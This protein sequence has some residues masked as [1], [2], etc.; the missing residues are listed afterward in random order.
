MSI[1][2]SDR[3]HNR[4]SCSACGL[5]GICLPIAVE[6]DQIAALESVVQQGR[7]L[8]RGDH[9]FRMDDP[10][11]CIYAVRSGCVKS[12]RLSERGEEQVLGFHLPGE[13]FALDGIG[14]SS[15]RSSAIAIETSSLC[16]IPFRQI[17]ELALRIPSMSAHLLQLMSHEIATDQHLAL[18]LNKRTADERVA[19]FLLGLSS[20]FRRRRLS[21]TRFRLPMSRRDLAN[22]LGL[23]VET[24]SRVLTRLQEIELI[25]VEAQE[26]EIL[27]ADGLHI[28]AGVAPPSQR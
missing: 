25:K 4:L 17:S 6:E 16:A 23:A 12:Y 9:V 20:R 19:A 18:L 14:E 24:M 3:G 2:C 28:A 8:R 13:I 1:I 5:A 11:D 7:P 21:S 27:D 22:Y 15:Y 26:F 10:F